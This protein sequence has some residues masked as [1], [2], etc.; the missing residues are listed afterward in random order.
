M[1]VVIGASRSSR[2]NI[3]GTGVRLWQGWTDYSHVYIKYFDQRIGQNV[4]C[5][6]SYGEVHLITEENWHKKNISVGEWEVD[7]SE[8][9]FHIMLLYIYD[10]LQSPYGYLTILGIFLGRTD[11]GADDDKSFICSELIV[12][13]LGNYIG[14]NPSDHVTPK[15]IVN[16]L[17][18]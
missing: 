2:F 8:Y 11:I 18:E 15:Q 4:I 1:K 13:I 17:R 16:A 3:F 7:I 5:E 14:L 12:R 10:K 9:D 6:A